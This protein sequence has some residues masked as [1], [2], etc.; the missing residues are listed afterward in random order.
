MFLYVPI[1][2]YFATAEAR[3][4]PVLFGSADILGHPAPGNPPKYRIKIGGAP[5]LG[6][7]VLVEI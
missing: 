1:S 3:S 5:G 6:A 4:K 2:Q 7:P